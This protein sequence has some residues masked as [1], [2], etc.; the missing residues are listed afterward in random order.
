MLSKVA[1]EKRVILFG[2]KP[3]QTEANFTHGNLSPADTIL[4]AS[5]L[6]LCASLT[7]LDLSRKRLCGVWYEQKLVQNAYGRTWRWDEQKGTYDAT[8]IKALADSLSA[9][10]S[11]TVLDVRHNNITGDGASQ[12]SSAIL[13][14]TNIEKFNEIPVKEMRAD[15]FTELELGGEYIGIEGGLVVSGLL[16]AMA[17]LTEV[18]LRGNSIGDEG[19]CAIFDA[20]RDNPQDKIAKWDLSNQGINPTTA[21]S[22]AAYAATSASLTQLDVSGNEISGDSALQLSAAVL[23]NPKIEKFN[24]IPIKEMRAD[25]LT[26]LELP[27]KRIGVVGGLIVSGLVPV[28]TS[29]A[30]LNLSDNRLCGLY[31]EYKGEPVRGNYDA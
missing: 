1:A 16:P 21:K 22:L 12:L 27:Q 4:I 17:S 20:L 23:S 30:T 6:S 31:E 2:I 24:E 15:S 28:M 10:T 8:G 7:T 25:S 9:H 19:W 26:T 13:A 3:D 5:D 11:L 18:N 14:N 29:L